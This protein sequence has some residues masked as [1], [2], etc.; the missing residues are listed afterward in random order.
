MNPVA[1]SLHPCGDFIAVAF[2]HYVNVFYIVGGGGGD[3]AGTRDGGSGGSSGGGG[4]ISMASSA[5][6]LSVPLPHS[7]AALSIDAAELDPLAVLRSDQREFMTKGMFSVAGEQDPV[8]NHD[9]ISALHYSPGGHLLAVVTG[10]V[11]ENAEE[12]VW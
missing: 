4:H 12:L 8:I 7:G 11:P 5:D 6:V 10:K 3:A 9:P 1:I 2:P